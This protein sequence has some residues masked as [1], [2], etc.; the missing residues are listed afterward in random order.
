MND[1]AERRVNRLMMGRDEEVEM[2]SREG[3]VLKGGILENLQGK[4]RF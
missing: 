3:E 2:V 4:R 1:K